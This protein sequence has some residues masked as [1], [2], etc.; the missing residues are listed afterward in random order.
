MDTIF[1]QATARGKSGVAV[2]RV[3][4]PDAVAG[5]GTLCAL[6][7]ARRAAL[8]KIYDGN[9][10]ILDEGLVLVFPEGSSFTG[11]PVVELQLHGSIAIVQAVLRA[12]D[13]IP[14]FRPADAGEFT[15]RALGNQRL[16][17]VQVEG[18][19]DLIEAETEAQRLQAQA[20]LAGA[21]SEKV[22]EW[23]NNLI[24]ASALLEVTLDFADE[25]VPVDVKPEVAAR[26]RAV[27]T[28][29]ESE[30]AGFAAAERVRDG[31]EVAIMG[32]PNAGKSTL[33]NAIAKRPVALTSEIAGTTRDVLEV[34][35]DLDGLPV[36]LL[37][38]AGIRET[39]DV[40]ESAGIELAR[41]RAR[42]AD[43]RVWL[44]LD[45]ASPPDDVDIVLRAQDDKGSLGGI[46]G[47]TGHGVSALLDQIG[48]VLAERVPQSR[49]AIRERHRSAMTRAARLLQ[50]AS[51]GLE[52]GLVPELV[53]EQLRDA[54]SCLAEIVGGIDVEDLLGEIFGRFCIGK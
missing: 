24:E 20:V 11:E 36:T 44:D 26:I 49:L 16:D 52:H 47:K 25:E 17:L 22:G 29:L 18:L 32:P 34:R 31:F 37:D 6:P 46:S 13:R 42:Q 8:R 4:G 54:S 41:S 28:S 5:V 40:L 19:A 35:I 15:R 39:Q 7:E 50:I 10:G 9:G 30:I 23:R 3:S 12:L 51:D 38:T 48:S 1:A 45:G 43:L 21:L 2:V 33:L 27:K 14:A 53:A